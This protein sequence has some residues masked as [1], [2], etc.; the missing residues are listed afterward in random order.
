MPERGGPAAR[1]VS[2]ANRGRALE[3]LVEW[4]NELY[5][6]RRV[7]VVH[8]VPAA[9]VPIRDARGKIVSAKVEKKAAVDF[10]GHVLLPGGAL[11]LAFDAKEVS[12]GS[13][14]P[15]ENLKAHQYEYLRDC[16]LTGALS[17]VLIA[18]WEKDQ[19]F[20]L[21]FP[22]LEDRW[23]A[24]RSGGPASVRAGDE[25]LVPVTFPDYLSFLFEGGCKECSRGRISWP[26]PRP[27]F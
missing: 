4:A 8:R 23:G 9:W 20:V 6:R 11:P 24:W 19:F 21:P 3:E 22:V 12:R 26:G 14:W 15:L 1:I 17:F 13:R 25:G 27:A 2:S 7:A 5:R 16:A 10:L 18:F